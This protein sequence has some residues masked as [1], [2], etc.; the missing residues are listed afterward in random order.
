MPELSVLLENGGIA[1][2]VSLVVAA[3]VAYFQGRSAARQEVAKRQNDLSIEVTKLIIEGDNSKAVAK[4]FAVGFVKV[5]VG[6]VEDELGVVC[7]IPISARITVGREPDNDVVLS[8]GDVSRLQCGFF[9]QGRDIFVEDYRSIDGTFVNGKKVAD[10][11]SKRLKD[12]DRIAI[13]DYEIEFQYVQRSKV[14][15]R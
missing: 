5:L 11:G 3:I 13:N 14:L 2:V 6:P 12:G 10:G 9:S 7:F 4:R 8:A 1:A 15:S